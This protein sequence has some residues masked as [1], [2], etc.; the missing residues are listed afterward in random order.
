[1]LIENVS[2]S[3]DNSWECLFSTVTNLTKIPLIFGAIYFFKVDSGIATELRD[4]KRKS[5]GFICLS[6]YINSKRIMICSIF[7]Q[8][9]ITSQKKEMDLHMHKN[10][11]HLS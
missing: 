11:L 9:R 4:G 3:G 10:L 2:K 7:L 8:Y 6:P 1:M 5:M